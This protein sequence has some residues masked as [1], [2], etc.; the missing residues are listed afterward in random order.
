MRLACVIFNY[1]P[2]SGLARDCL[3]IAQHAQQKEHSVTV[4]ANSW[5]GPRPEGINVEIINSRGLSNHAQA[6]YFH[7]AVRPKLTRDRHDLV[8]GFNKMPD[9][10]VYYAGDDCFIAKAATRPYWYQWTPRFRQYAGFER[11]VCAPEGHTQILCL[12]ERQRSDFQCFHL[13]PDRRLHAVPPNLDPA[14][15]PVTGPAARRRAR[16]ALGID[17]SQLLLLMVGSGFHTK[18]VDRAIRALASLPGE[19][20]QQCVLLIA[21]DGDSAPFRELARQ[22][23]VETQLR[24]LG[25][26]EDVADLLS[27]ADVLLHPARREA[28]G[29]IL[30]EALISGVRIL[31]LSVCGHATYVEQAQAGSVL[32]EPFT[33]GD[34][35]QALLSLLQSDRE[36]WRTQS[37]VKLEAMDFTSMAEHVVGKLEQFSQ[38]RKTT[39]STTLSGVYLKEP[40]LSELPNDFD[41]LL[42]LSEEVFR[43]AHARRTS[44]FH[45]NGKDFFIKAHFGVGWREIVK[46]W[47]NLRAP[48]TGAENE[49]YAL[50]RLP[51]LG[52]AIA[53]AAGFGRRGTSPARRQ[54]FVI[55]EKVEA[56]SLERVLLHWQEHPPSW[57]GQVRFKRQLIAELARIARQLHSSGLNHQDFYLCHFWIPWPGFPQ[58]K[59]PAKIKIYLMDLHRVQQRPKTSPRWRRKDLAGL[60]FSVLALRPTKTDRLRFI[61]HYRQQPL[62]DIMTKEP[63]FWDSV[64]DRA[65]RL[66]RTHDNIMDNA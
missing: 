66:D 20:C 31:T 64:S 36:R 8:L 58:Q 13:T 43:E 5:R 52:I 47:S 51:Q 30:L 61:H 10:D 50:H 1:F 38:T 18:G 25:V 22:L 14:F 57:P 11:A 56:V 46:N 42:Q 48:I 34:L 32:G 27:A 3:R 12:S 16:A 19:L 39:P 29:A 35:N 15:K 37:S 28:G 4:Y 7:R 33:Q 6:K 65:L 49:W 9:L 40:L 45:C 54:S 59:T 41:K 53:G 60:Y 21:G 24:F 17:D 26:R 55:T 23:N 2:D 62:R 63:A 44:R